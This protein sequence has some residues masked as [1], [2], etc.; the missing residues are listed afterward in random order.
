M[1]RDTYW[2]AFGNVS[3]GGSRGGEG[4][5]VIISKRHVLFINRNRVLIGS[6]ESW[7]VFLFYR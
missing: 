5:E 6:E 2:R 4:K 7:N 1:V 3:G